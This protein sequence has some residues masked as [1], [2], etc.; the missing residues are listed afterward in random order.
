MARD[1]ICIPSG[2]MVER[3]F[4]K[5]PT[6]TSTKGKT[7]KLAYVADFV[8]KFLYL[9]ALILARRFP[10]IAL[11]P[12]K[13]SKI[14][15]TSQSITQRHGCGKL[16]AQKNPALGGI[17]LFAGGCLLEAAC[18]R[19]LACGLHPHHIPSTLRQPDL[20]AVLL[21]FAHY[22]HLLQQVTKHSCI[23]LGLR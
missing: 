15:P 9:M 1:L 17:S 3:L 16:L 2:Y 18:W 23:N 21:Y 22:H 10:H 20:G 6:S 4:L 11:D 12:Q 13:H 7:R 14:T 5:I 19:L 8:G